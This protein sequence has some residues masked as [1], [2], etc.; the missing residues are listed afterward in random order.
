[1]C[2]SGRIIFLIGRP[3]DPL[4]RHGGSLIGGGYLHTRF[5]INTTCSYRISHRQSNGS[6]AEQGPRVQDLSLTSIHTV[7]HSAH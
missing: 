5:P 1:M 3:Y 6:R 4:H 2:Q 7:D